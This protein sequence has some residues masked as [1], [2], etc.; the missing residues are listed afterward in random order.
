MRKLV[1]LAPLVFLVGCAS[2]GEYYAAVADANA[3]MAEVEAIKAEAESKRIEAL[4]TLASTGSDG[5]RSAATVALALSG[6]NQG[7]KE[8]SSLRLP[9]KARNPAL[10]WA[11]VV[12]PFVGQIT[13][14]Y[15]NYSLGETQSNNSRDI[16]L[17]THEAFSELGMSEFR[18]T[19][20]AR[21]KPESS[22]D[23]GDNRTE[24]ELERL[25]Q[26]GE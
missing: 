15:Y 1:I 3:R 14:G 16:A 24:I 19:D 10:E 18:E 6:A 25:Q 4:V 8:E 21:Y 26:E 7:G 5:D 11:S 17:S 12:L 13:T 2:S 9:Q 20:S 23:L 22:Y